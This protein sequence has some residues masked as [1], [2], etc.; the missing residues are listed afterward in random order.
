MYILYYI[1]AV[2]Y[3]SLTIFF[4]VMCDGMAE[5]LRRPSLCAGGSGVFWSCCDTGQ[6]KTGEQMGCENLISAWRK[7]EEVVKELTENEIQDL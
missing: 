4:W 7:K 5:G 1:F 2:F 6:G 3:L